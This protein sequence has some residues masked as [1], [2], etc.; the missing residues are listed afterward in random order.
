MIVSRE[1][2]YHWYDHKLVNHTLPEWGIWAFLKQLAF[3]AWPVRKGL[4]S[5]MK[6]RAH[7]AEKSVATKKSFLSFI[8][9]HQLVPEGW[10]WQD[11]GH[12]RLQER[13][14]CWNENGRVVNL[15]LRQ[16]GNLSFHMS[17]WENASFNW[18]SFI[19]SSSLPF[20]QLTFCKHPILS[21]Y[22]FVNMPF[23]ALTF[24]Q[25]AI[26]LTYFLPTCNLSTYFLSTH[27]YQ[28]V[29]SSPWHL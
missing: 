25:P 6:T 13:E 21:T 15:L 11:Q 7:C 23:Y 4:M 28:L 8:P 29:T 1:V 16:P 26:L 17:F 9:R 5:V 18:H 27:F 12:Q 10:C 22:F 2:H 3:R 14:G 24:C 19:H 20:Y